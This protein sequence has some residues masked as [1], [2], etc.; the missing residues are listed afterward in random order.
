MLARLR[1]KGNPGALVVG[2]QTGAAIWKTVW[3]LLT[4][5]KMEIPSDP[6]IPLLAIYPK[7]MKTLL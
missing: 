2:V 1:R 3:R 6:G 5:L 7:K 4:K